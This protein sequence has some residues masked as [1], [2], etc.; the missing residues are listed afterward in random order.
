MHQS[1]I[2]PDSG[3]TLVPPVAQRNSG[4]SWSKGEI[5]AYLAV[6]FAGMVI[7]WMV[8]LREADDLRRAQARFR[9]ESA[10]ATTDTAQR[11]ES[12]FRHI[13]EGLRTMARLPGVRGIDRHAGNFTADAR[14]TVQEIYNNL[15]LGAALSE[16]Y[17]VPRDLEPDQIDPFTGHPQAPIAEF[18]NLIVGR[19]VKSTSRRDDEEPVAEEI[20]IFEYRLMKQQLAR[21]NSEVSDETRVAGLNYPAL[22]GH[23]VVTCDNTRFDPVHPNDSSRSGLV[24]AVPFFS[25]DGQL[26]GSIAAVFLTSALRELLGGGRYVLHQKS[27]GYRASSIDDGVWR[28]SPQALQGKAD[29]NLIYSEVRTLSIIDGGGRWQLWAGRPNAEFWSRPDASAVAQLAVISYFVVFLLMICMIAVVRWVSTRRAHIAELDG[30]VRERTQDLEAARDKALNAAA[31][32][33]LARDAAL[34]AERAKSQFLANMSH[35]IRT[36]MNGVLGMTDLLLRTEL[37]DQQRHYA[38]VI[39]R[40]GEGLLVIINDILDYS[41]YEAGAL[42]LE[43]IDINLRMLLE[44]VTGMLEDRAVVKG[45]RLSCDMAADV[46]ALI[47]GDPHRINQVLMNLLGNAVKFTEFG[48]VVLGVSSCRGEGD[49]TWL[50]FNVRDTGIGMT[51][52]TLEQ[53]FQPFVQA[54][55]STTR[56]YGGT[57]LGLM[58]SRKLVTLLGGELKITSA[59]GDGTSAQFS[60]PLLPQSSMLKTSDETMVRLA[61]AEAYTLRQ[62][63]LRLSDV[64]V[65]D[66]DTINREIAQAQ[67]EAMGCR[68]HVATNGVEAIAAVE[69]QRFD[70]IFMDCQMP[71]MDGYTASRKIRELALPGPRVPIIAFTAGV[72]AS[73]RAACATAGMDDYLAKPVRQHELQAMLGKY[74]GEVE[75]HEA[76]VRE[77]KAASGG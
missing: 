27:N 17:I 49:L 44:D 11:I 50:N 62:N 19:T 64:L 34:E 3:A 42:K 38:S 54:D 43:V 61:E 58:I 56:K 22:S 55:S 72:I 8:H 6:V 26:H 48:E 66:D 24:Y 14:T 16:V 63:G 13:Y 45:I 76:F 46:P 36:P 15:A 39:H 31:E 71:M 33:E 7:A 35:E 68:V 77:R 60:I 4:R 69:R 30:R 20:E 23:E 29:V 65:V 41:K 47:R 57:G 2:S 74:L 51:P 10:S 40:S 73:E 37:N 53:L 52:A 75:D 25:P 12:N 70:L 5:L 18:D 1:H 21:F 67:L 32:L 28:Q 9:T 59:L